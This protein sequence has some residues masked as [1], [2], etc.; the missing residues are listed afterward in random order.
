MERTIKI[1][2]ALAVVLAG[3]WFFIS[4]YQPKFPV[5]RRLAYRDNNSFDGRVVGKTNGTLLAEVRIDV[6]TDTVELPIISL[7]F[8]DQ[9]YAHWL[10][11]ASPPYP[12]TRVITDKDGRTLHVHILGR[13][14]EK[15]TI[16]RISDQKRFHIPLI[17]LSGDDQRFVSKL[18]RSH[19]INV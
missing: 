18:P 11:E 12:V 6:G 1:L 9:L 4:K 8:L 15:I 14:H 10:P 5:E 13:T 19:L 16:E 2:L 7:R 3:G 17:N